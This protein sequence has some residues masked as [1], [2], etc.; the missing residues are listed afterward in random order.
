MSVRNPIKNPNISTAAYD[1]EIH[2]DTTLDAARRIITNRGLENLTIA[3]LAD[4]MGMDKNL[5]YTRLTI[6]ADVLPPILL[7]IE[8]DIL[9]L[10]KKTTAEHSSPETAFVVLFNDLYEILLQKPH[11]LTLLFDERLMTTNRKVG[12]ALMRIRGIAESHLESLIESG[13]NTGVFINGRTST[14]LAKSIMT[15]FRSMMKDE[16][17]INVMLLELK[18]RETGIDRQKTNSSDES[19]A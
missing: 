9:A 1:I 2:K 7:R 17:S 4:E 18:S 19:N 10:F 15:S 3:N 12:E 14:S 16:H 11:Y 6:E 13:K 8:T 5:L